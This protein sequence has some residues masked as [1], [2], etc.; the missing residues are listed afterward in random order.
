MK[1]NCIFIKLFVGLFLLSGCANDD[2][3]IS[4]SNKSES[5]ADES[6]VNEFVWLAMNQFYFWQSRVPELSDDIARSQITLDEFISGFNS[7]ESLFDNLLY[8]ED[9]FSWIEKDYEV[10]ESSFQGINTSFGY[11]FR[12]VNPEGTRQVFGYVKYVVPNSPASEAKIK[13]GDL[14]TA[15]DGVELTL[16]NYLSLVFNQSSYV[17]TMGEVGAEGVVKSTEKTHALLA[18]EVKE[19]P[20]HYS[21]VI[22][23]GSTKVGY[24]VYN[25][26][27]N[28][29]QY[30]LELNN[31]FKKFL[32]DGVSELVLDLRYN[33]GGSVFT[34]Q[35]LGSLIY[36]QGTTTTVFGSIVYNEKLT[37]IF[38]NSDL[39]FY[40]M[41]KL[42][43]SQQGAE[44]NRLNLNRLFVLTSRNTASA[45]ELIIAALSSYMDITI[46]GTTTVGKNVGS[47]TLYDSPSEAYL[48]KGNDLNPNHKYALQPIISQLANADGFSDYTKGFTPDIRVD[49]LDFVGR[50]KSLG[51]PEEA[52]LDEALMIISGAA[53]KSEK[54]NTVL[55]ANLIDD[56]DRLKKHIQTIKLE[57]KL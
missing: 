34:S 3:V 4:D 37:K 18:I 32:S 27:V 1:L 29:D 24:L 30:H 52:L 53:R 5:E 6:K 36:G 13:R 46:I 31:V 11:E 38:S 14:F 44:L 17:L 7:P 35:L 41:N 54:S 55:K 8:S 45:S 21:S 47:V 10:L 50:M 49:E 20:I 25:Q 48:N 56:S 16:D 2:S 22:D 42:S 23:L 40:F 39:N 33:P 12:L 43:S 26:F 15:I 51:D 57:L 28:N 19:N 9:R